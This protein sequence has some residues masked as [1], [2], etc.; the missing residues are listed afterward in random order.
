MQIL[1]SFLFVVRVA[2]DKRIQ[3]RKQREGRRRTAWIDRVCYFRY[4][5]I[6]LSSLC[7][8]LYTREHTHALRLYTRRP[9]L[10]LPH[11]WV[12]A[13]EAHDATQLVHPLVMAIFLFLY[14]SFFVFYKKIYFYFRNLQKYTPAAQLPGSRHLVAPLP[15]GRDLSVKIFLKKLCSGP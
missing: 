9:I 2:L 1:S 13:H 11:C 10:F 6:L 3:R 5:L 12:G 4:K 7:S 14:F 15:G 8:L